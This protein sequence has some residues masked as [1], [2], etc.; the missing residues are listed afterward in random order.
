MDFSFEVPF[1]KYF[2]SLN[3][4]E[5]SSHRHIFMSPHAVGI[6]VNKDF[7][8]NYARNHIGNVGPVLAIVLLVSWTIL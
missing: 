7:V 8:L 3:S 4:I 6:T 1:G 2:A 5:G